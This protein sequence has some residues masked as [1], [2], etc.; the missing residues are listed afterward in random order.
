M[1]EWGIELGTFFLGG[2]RFARTREESW[3]SYSLK[4]GIW[5]GD[6]GQKRVELNVPVKDRV[7]DRVCRRKQVQGNGLPAAVLT[8]RNLTSGILK[9]KSNISISFR[10][11]HA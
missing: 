5:A 7:Y 4:K 2:A 9:P 1:R 11:L 6:S 8:I 3:I 10:N